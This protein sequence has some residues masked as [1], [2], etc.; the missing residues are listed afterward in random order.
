MIFNLDNPAQENFPEQPGCYIF[1]D[2]LQRILYIGKSKCLKQRILSYFRQP[3][4]IPK[5]ARMVKS[6]RMVECT[7]TETD[8]EALLLEYTLIKKHRP[9]YN[10]RM[11]KDYRE[12]YI[13]VNKNLGLHG[14]FVFV[15]N[16]DENIGNPENPENSEPPKKPDENKKDNKK[17]TKK[18]NK[19]QGKKIFHLGPF[20]RKHIADEFLELL[21]ECFKIP[22]CGFGKNFPQKPCPR[23]HLKRCFAPCEMFQILK[24]TKSAKAARTQKSPQR[25]KYLGLTN[26]VAAEVLTFLTGNFQPALDSATDLMQQAAQQLE[27]ERAAYLRDKLANLNTLARQIVRI[28]PD[29]VNKNYYVLLKSHHDDTT[30]LC[31]YLQNK[32]LVEWTR[33]V[34]D[35]ATFMSF[36]HLSEEENLVLSKAVLEIDAVRNFLEV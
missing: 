21:G 12:S 13:A 4:K 6:A 3:A 33:F 2:S 34:G 11:V 35:K 19:K 25:E 23:F 30:L 14:F 16:P 5:I 10:A 27:F 29:L 26:E 22:T 24:E 32:R 28:P 36:A 17:S 31:A 7:C 1:R 18:S 15:K 8:I 9:P 20:Y